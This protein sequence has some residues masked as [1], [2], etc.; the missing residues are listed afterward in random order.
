[1]PLNAQSYAEL[2]DQPIVMNYRIAS[3]TATL[4]T[5]NSPIRMR[6]P[7]VNEEIRTAFLNLCCIANRTAYPNTREPVIPAD[8][9][10]AVRI[11]VIPKICRNTFS[12]SWP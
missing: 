9:T 5:A 6:N 1:M 10:N 3:P 7:M 4:A 8:I 2:K 12:S 11:T